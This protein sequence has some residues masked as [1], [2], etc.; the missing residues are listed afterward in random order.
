M[1][2]VKKLYC[3]DVACFE[4]K[5]MQTNGSVS[6]GDNVVDKSIVVGK[7]FEVA[8]S[9]TETGETFPKVAIAW[10]RERLEE[11]RRQPIEQVLGFSFIKLFRG[12]IM[13]VHK[14]KNR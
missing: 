8:V 12:W 9:E 2:T 1:Q 11:H 7:G 5:M 13:F 3:Y 4:I 10:I 14:T 6:L